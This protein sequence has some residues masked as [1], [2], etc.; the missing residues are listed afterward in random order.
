MKLAI[1]IDDLKNVYACRL[2]VERLYE[3]LVGNHGE[4]EAASMFSDVGMHGYSPQAIARREF[5]NA[6]GRFQDDDL[7]LVLEYYAMSKPSKRK[8]AVELAK[9]NETLP[10]E[11]RF[12]RGS[13]EPA[14]MLQQIKRVFREHKNDCALIGKA[15]LA[16]RDQELSKVT[17]YCIQSRNPRFREAYREM[18]GR[19]P[20]R[21]KRP[22]R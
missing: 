11:Q 19:E 17:K 4:A 22:S 9:R 8:L 16:L 6:C 5:A 20:G 21:K 7:R 12:Y 14:T 1:E 15:D 2:A 3:A 18:T 13:R 10:E